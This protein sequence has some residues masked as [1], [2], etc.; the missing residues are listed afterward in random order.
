MSNTDYEN[1]WFVCKYSSRINSII[2]KYSK[3]EFRFPEY[4]YQV[5][6]EQPHELKLEAAF[7]EK[8]QKFIINESK[9]D[10]YQLFVLSCIRY[11]KLLQ[12]VITIFNQYEKKPEERKRYLLKRTFAILNND[13]SQLNFKNFINP[14]E[15]INDL[16]YSRNSLVGYTG[17]IY[18]IRSILENFT[19]E[20]LLSSDLSTQEKAIEERLKKSDFFVSLNYMIQKYFDKQLRV[21]YVNGMIGFY[22]VD[23]ND[24]VSYFDDLSD[25]E[26]S[27]LTMIFWLYGNDLTDGFMIVNEPELHLHPQYQKE[28]AEVCDQ[29]SEHIGAQFILSTNSPL[30]INE[31]N[32]TS[33]YRMYKN[34]NQNSLVSAPRINVDYDDATLMHML[35]FENLSKLFFV[36]KI[37]LVEGDTDAYFFS[38]YLNYL[39]TF[40][41]WKNK[42][43]DYEIININGKGSFSTRRKFLRKFNIK[44]YFIGDWDNTVDYGFFSRAE[45]NRFYMLADKQAKT[46]KSEKRY[47][48]YYNRLVKTILTFAP[49]KHKAIIKG[50]EKLYNDKVFILKEGAIE[51]Y[52]PLEKKGLSYMAYFCNAYFYDRILNQNFKEQRK[53]LNQIMKIIFND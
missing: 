34:K 48:D 44:N 47:S 14:H 9:L 3:L 6:V 22:M 10:E 49:K 50:I 24:R 5:I 31:K 17:C 35:R 42:I 36:D 29:I 13:R 52:V 33:V 46:Q 20:A 12:I 32:L 21:D 38:F 39:K 19:Q 27:L 40:P 26:K 2:D 11:Q 45:L 8:L 28:L 4:K 43:R 41:E 1:I 53:E 51:T 25:G 30:F 18:K 23:E 15:I 37:I 7:D 16:E